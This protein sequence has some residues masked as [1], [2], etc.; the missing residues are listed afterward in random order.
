MSGVDNNTGVAQ[1]LEPGA[2]QWRRLHV[3]WEN[4]TGAAD[5]GVDAQAMNPLAQAVG[6]EAF[7]QRG[8]MPG[9]F[10]ITREERRIRL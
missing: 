10:G 1:T 5:E 8:N 9:P 3:S 6:V 2:Q 4:T 7:K